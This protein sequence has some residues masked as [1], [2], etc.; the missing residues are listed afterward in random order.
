[1]R[2]VRLHSGMPSHQNLQTTQRGGCFENF[3][4]LIGGFD[5]CH[6]AWNSCDEVRN[7][8]DTDR[9]RVM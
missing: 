3:D 1:M 5:D 9:D 2:V 6:R 4:C 8:R 7:R